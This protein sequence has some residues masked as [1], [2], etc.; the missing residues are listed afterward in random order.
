[1]VS[2][3][4][5]VRRVSKLQAAALC[6]RRAQT[7]PAQPFAAAGESDG[8][9]RRQDVRD[10]GA[11]AGQAENPGMLNVRMFFK[12]HSS[13]SSLDLCH[14]M[15]TTMSDVDDGFLNFFFIFFKT[16]VSGLPCAH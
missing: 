9:V 1:M 15:M 12:T 16:R 14:V 5:K 13:T 10:V 11:V 7:L 6:V 2:S 8:R 4:L 3:S